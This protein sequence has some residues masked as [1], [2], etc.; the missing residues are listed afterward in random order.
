[1]PS[2]ARLTDRRLCDCNPA[3]RSALID[4]KEHGKGQGTSRR[5]GRVFQLDRAAQ[6]GVQRKAWRVA[7]SLPRA[8]AL[9]TTGC[10]TCIPHAPI[11]PVQVL[12]L[13]ATFALA[14]PLVWQEKR[15][16]YYH[17][18]QLVYEWDQSLDEVVCVVAAVRLCRGRCLCVCVCVCVHI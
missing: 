17:Q 7:G 16:Q 11:F 3:C 1:M 15:K 13:W 5:V 14:C 9:P 10:D 18:G 6:G 4:A 2:A 12:T 8:S